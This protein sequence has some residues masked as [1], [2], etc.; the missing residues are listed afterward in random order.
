M[1][2]LETPMLLLVDGFCHWEASLAVPFAV[3][4]VLHFLVAYGCCCCSRC[5]YEDHVHDHHH[6]DIAVPSTGSATATHGPSFV[7]VV[8]VV[9]SLTIPSVLVAVVATTIICPSSVCVVS[10]S[11]VP[12]RHKSHH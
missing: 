12:I 4:V 1:G 6:Y 5:D 9:A 8:L 3:V 10:V 11:T 7:L 2:W